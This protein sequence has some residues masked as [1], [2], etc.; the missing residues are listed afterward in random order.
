VP[1]TRSAWSHRARR[2]GP[3]GRAEHRVTVSPHP[4]RARRRPPVPPMLAAWVSEVDQ[5]RPQG[6]GR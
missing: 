3:D 2:A 1:W 4:R 5:V 6:P